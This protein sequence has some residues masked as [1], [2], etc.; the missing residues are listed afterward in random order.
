MVSLLMHVTGKLI[1]PCARIYVQISM[2]NVL[3][4]VQQSASNDQKLTTLCQNRDPFKTL[5]QPI[6]SVE[7]IVIGNRWNVKKDVPI[8]VHVMLLSQS[9]MH[10]TQNKLVFLHGRLAQWKER[11]PSRNL[12]SFL[13]KVH[14]QMQLAPSSLTIKCLLLGGNGRPT[15]YR[16]LTDAS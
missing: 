7:L 1:P 14:Q 9:L 3:K 13:E 5:S 4:H 11:K 8:K 12:H 2:L 15:R 10:F 16:L 6:R